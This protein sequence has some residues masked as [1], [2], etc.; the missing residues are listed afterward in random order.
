M[1]Q[2][3]RPNSRSP[4]C[5]S[6][7]GSVLQGCPSTGTTSVCPD[8]TTPP[9]TDGPMVASKFDL[10]PSAL[11]TRRCGKPRSSR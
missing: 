8:S 11:G 2:V 10:V 1:S 3:P 9:A 6:V 4:F 7:K 5:V